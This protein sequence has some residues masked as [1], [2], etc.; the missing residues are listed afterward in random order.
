MNRHDAAAAAPGD[1]TF[2]ATLV[3]ELLA[4]WPP[5]RALDHAWSYTNPR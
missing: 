4:A 3:L 5:I 2:T 1:A